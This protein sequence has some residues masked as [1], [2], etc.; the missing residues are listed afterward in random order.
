MKKLLACNGFCLTEPPFFS[1]FEK[2]QQKQTNLTDLADQTYLNYLT[3]FTY[4]TDLSC[5][6]KRAPKADTRSLRT[7]NPLIFFGEVR[8]FIARISV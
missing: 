5:L 2:G 7:K 4:L 6:L 8:H 3:Y 1:I